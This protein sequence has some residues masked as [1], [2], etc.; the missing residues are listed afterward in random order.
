ML[1]LS[2][3]IPGGSLMPEGVAAVPQSNAEQI[4]TKCRYLLEIGY[5]CTEATGGIL[6]ALTDEEVE[7]VIAENEKS[8]LKIVSVN[9]LFPWQWSLSDPSTDKEEYL[10]RTRRIFDIMQKLGVHNAI[11]GSGGARSLK[12]EVGLDVS[13]ATL[14][15]FMRKVADEAEKRD[16]KLL[17]EPLNKRETN[18]FVTVEESC[19]SIEEIGHPNIHL[20]YDSFHMAMERTSLDCIKD[21]ISQVYHCHIAEAPNRSY[22]GSTDS[23]DFAYNCRYLKELTELGYEGVVSVECGFKDFKTDTVKALAHMKNILSGKAIFQYKAPRALTSEPVYLEAKNGEIPAGT[24]ALVCGDKKY[25]A[26]P[27]K[28][29]VIAIITAERDEALNLVAVEEEAE[30]GAEIIHKE[31]EKKAEV[32]VQGNLFA[33]YVYDPEIPKPFLG[34]IYDNAGNNFTRKEIN[35]REH[36]HQRSV[37]IAVGD[38]NGVDCWNEYGNYGYV[39]NESVYDIYSGSAYATFSVKNRWTDL[40]NKPLITENTRYFVYNQSEDCRTLDIEVT[41]TADYGDVEFG[42]TKEAGPLGIRLRDELRADI[43]C[44]QF[45]N[46]W[47]GVGE[48]ECWGR[49]AEWCDYY[50]EPEE[51]GPMGVTVFDCETNERHPTAWHIRAY[52]LFAANN[53]YFKGGFTIKAGESKVYK[54]RILF[55]R[56]PMTKDEIADKYVTYTLGKK[57]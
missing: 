32:K 30:L 29:G 20:L 25:P 39:R 9:S 22:P 47:G 5:D 35:H 8:S 43:G 3:C 53:L 2:C 24:T 36:K 18:I 37:F 23:R 50:G 41:F 27:Y 11:F 28:N 46:S 21:T 4:V 52:G 14:Y 31:D 45:I 33:N 44:G 54:F 34:P 51:I 16:I 57:I 10:V 1:K 6:A 56:K 42:A 26:S 49:T 13:R 38:V 17:I 19:K 7:Y 15:D 12:E 48:G 40:E 55:R